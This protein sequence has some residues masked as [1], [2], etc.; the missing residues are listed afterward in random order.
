MFPQ[1]INI[2]FRSTANN[3]LQL[4]SSQTM[5]VRQRY[6]IRQSLQDSLYLEFKFIYLPVLKHFEVF[7]QL[8]ELYLH[9]FTVMEHLMNLVIKSTVCP[10]QLISICV[11]HCLLE[12]L[13]RRTLFQ[14]T[15]E[16]G[17]LRINFIQI[18]ISYLIMSQ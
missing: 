4:I 12:L 15:Y 13:L 18:L 16:T 2:D 7:S 14:H 3:Q 11:L 1:Q 10:S 17:Q 6:Q 9:I 8:F 5:Q